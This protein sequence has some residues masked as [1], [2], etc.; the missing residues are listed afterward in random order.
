MAARRPRERPG[1][2]AAWLGGLRDP[3]PPAQARRVPREPPPAR[4]NPLSFGPR[5]FTRRRR[6]DWL[7]DRRA[8]TDARSR[9]PGG[10]GGVRWARVLRAP[11]AGGAGRGGAERRRL[12]LER[13]RARPDASRQRAGHEETLA[14][15]L[16]GREPRRSVPLAP[17]APRP[18]GRALV[19][20]RRAVPQCAGG[21]AR[22][23]F[24]P[25]RVARGHP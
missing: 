19:A 1:R 15:R 9:R 11:P 25:R 8:A 7:R 6:G 17:L 20:K 4:R 13:S 14:V 23:A 24:G 10:R 16:P 21:A 22:R 12:F 5:P 2:V 18:R 3:V